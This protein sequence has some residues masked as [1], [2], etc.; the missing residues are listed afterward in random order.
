MKK[1]RYTRYGV[2][3]DLKH[4]PF[5]ITRDFNPY[6]LYQDKKGYPLHP[7][8]SLLPDRELAGF[9]MKEIRS[10]SRM[11]KEKVIS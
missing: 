4:S 7:L 11:Y 5:F 1:R 10:P 6:F 2:T 9:R 8:H 3:D